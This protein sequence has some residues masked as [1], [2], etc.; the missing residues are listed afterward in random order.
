MTW[1]F[2]FYA[3]WNFSKPLFAKG[4]HPKH[5]SNEHAWLHCSI[6]SACWDQIRHALEIGRK[7]KKWIVPVYFQVQE[8]CHSFILKTR[9]NICNVSRRQIHLSS[10]PLL[11]LPLPIFISIERKVII[12]YVGPLG[13]LKIH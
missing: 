5:R 6:S 3:P 13:I 1:R 12:L 7:K 2:S 10:H 4:N 8:S 9:L 11:F